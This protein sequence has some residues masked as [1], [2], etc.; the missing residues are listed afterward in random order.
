MVRDGKEFSRETFGPISC[1]ST[2]STRKPCTQ[3]KDFLDQAVQ[4]I[5]VYVLY[6]ILMFEVEPI[7][8]YFC[9]HWLATYY[10]QLCCA[11]VRMH[12]CFTHVQFKSGTV[13]VLNRCNFEWRNSCKFHLNPNDRAIDFVHTWTSVTN[14]SHAIAG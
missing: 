13:I 8:R 9:N 1:V 11:V 2:P 12:V 14:V 4:V 5:E 7:K 3:A 6:C 10:I